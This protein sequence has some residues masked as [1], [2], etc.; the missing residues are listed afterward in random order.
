MLHQFKDGDNPDQY[1]KERMSF[2]ELAFRDR[3]N[4]VA[5]ADTL[6]KASAKTNAFKLKRRSMGSPDS[7]TLSLQTAL[8]NLVDQNH[9]AM[10]STLRCRSNETRGQ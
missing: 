4:S 3:T 9:S 8:A 1:M 2:I 7:P 10:L 5:A 6:Y